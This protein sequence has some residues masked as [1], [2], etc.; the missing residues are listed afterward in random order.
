M[1]YR[2]YYYFCVKNTIH[3]KSLVTGLE[4]ELKKLDLD[5]SDYYSPVKVSGNSEWLGYFR[6]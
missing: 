2:L 6:C 5:K 3:A 4:K 1:D